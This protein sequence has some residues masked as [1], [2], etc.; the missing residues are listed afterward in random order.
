MRLQHLTIGH[1]AGMRLQ[2]LAFLARNDVEMQV[3]HGLA[4]RRFVE[5]GDEHAIRIEGLL[6]SHCEFL[7]HGDGSCQHFRVGIEQ[8]AGAGLGN[9]QQMAGACGITS[10]KASVCSSS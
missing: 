10:M 4:S 6:G 9:D 1:Y 5:L 8:I 2:R 7:H 3:E